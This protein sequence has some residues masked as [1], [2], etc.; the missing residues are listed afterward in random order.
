[1]KNYKKI[2][3]LCLASICVA[4]LVYFMGLFSVRAYRDN[5][6]YRENQNKHNV[7]KASLSKSCEGFSEDAVMKAKEFCNRFD[8]ACGDSQVPSSWVFIDYTVPESQNRQSSWLRL[9]RTYGTKTF[10]F[11]KNDPSRILKEIRFGVDCKTKEVY[12]YDNKWQHWKYVEKY[13]GSSPFKT[14][15]PEPMLEKNAKQIVDRIAQ[16]MV[17][18]EDMVFDGMKN[19]I[20]LGVWNA[21]WVRKK[22][23]YAYEDDWMVISIMAATGEL[24]GYEKRYRMQPCPTV[25]N[26]TREH[27]IEIARGIFRNKVPDRVL[28]KEK[29]LFTVSSNT[30]IVQPSRYKRPVNESEAIT[31]TSSRLAWV[32]EYHP[33][34]PDNPPEGINLYLLHMHFKVIIDAATGEVIYTSDVPSSVTKK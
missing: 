31:D 16:R 28:E 5:K 8:L 10:M 4:I 12:L 26:I 21:F 7:L 18:P 34:E 30:L 24:I 19:E 25:A 3:F 32:I 33:S 27:A 22:D 2:S 23:G 1:M 6:A 17:M 29:D 20:T 11:E 14:R 15:W 13:G 9:Y